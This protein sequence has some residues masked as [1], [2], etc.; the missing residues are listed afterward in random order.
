MLLA[1]S[2]SA[3]LGRVR[4]VKA[5]RRIRRLGTVV[6]STWLV[7]SCWALIVLL[8][9][10]VNAYQSFTTDDAAAM[11]WMRSNVGPSDVVVNDTYA[12]AGVWAPYKAGVQILLP[13]AFYD[14]DTHADRLLVVANVAD[15][16]SNPSA[17]A[18]AC[19]FHA[20]YVYYGAANSKWISR[21]FPSVEELQSSSGLQQVFQEGKAAVFAI[22]L[23][24]S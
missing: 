11:A 7:L 22:K 13:R 9:M 3:L 5:H 20:R 6:V 16:E 23:A 1:G 4:N 10:Q 18:A 19:G 8:G 14:P 2:W 21:V 12:D 17:A 15:L 24:C